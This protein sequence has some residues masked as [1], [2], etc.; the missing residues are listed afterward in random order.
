[1][2]IKKLKKNW[3]A[4]GKIDPLWAIITDPDKKGG[5][6]EVNEFFLSGIEEINSVVKYLKG[7]PVQINYKRALDFGCGV[8]RLTQALACYF[9]EVCGIDIA[10]SMLMSARQFNRYPDKCK[11]YLNETNDLSLFEN[12]S[13]NFIY[14]NIVLQHMEPRYSKRYIEE[15]IR[16]LVA[17]GVLVFQMPSSC[18]GRFEKIKQVIQN[19]FPTFYELCVKLKYGSNYS[20]MEMHAIKKE[21]MALFLEKIGGKILDIQSNPA[22]G[23]NWVNATYVV[24]KE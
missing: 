16:I 15:F 17:H 13:F 10:P 4:L 12:D 9:E 2:D 22:E 23:E 3:D 18:A 20:V 6:W 11:Y 1:M 5:K 8:G 24:T 19:F 7:L 14:S 21:E